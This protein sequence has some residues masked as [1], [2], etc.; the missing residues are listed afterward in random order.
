MWWSNDVFWCGHLSFPASSC[1]CRKT[2]SG[3]DIWSH[4]MQHP[5]QS[6]TYFK[7][8]SGCSGPYLA[9]LWKF[10]KTQIPQARWV[11]VLVLNCSHCIIFFSSYLTLISIIA[12]GDYCILS[13][14]FGKSYPFALGRVILLLWEVWFAVLYDLFLH[15]G[16]LQLDPTL[17]FSSG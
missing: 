14:C 6:C 8:R 13:F 9:D 2:E 16:R 10:P 17:A 3:K 7:V 4:P 11:P 12:I 1:Y 15:H 5:A